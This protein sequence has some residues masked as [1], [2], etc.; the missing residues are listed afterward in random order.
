MQL[1]VAYVESLFH[2]A[3][4]A[5]AVMNRPVSGF[6]SWYCHECFRI[7]HFIYALFRQAWRMCVHRAVARG[8]YLRIELIVS[9]HFS[10]FLLQFSHLLFGKDFFVLYRRDLYELVDISIPI[11][12]HR[13]SQL[14]TGV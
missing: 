2:F 8:F 4:V 7:S 10:D 1:A 6:L 12:E 14:R 11:V 3:E 9:L 5:D 13:A